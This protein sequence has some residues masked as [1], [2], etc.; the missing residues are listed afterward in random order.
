[1][2]NHRMNFVFKYILIILVAREVLSLYSPYY[3]RCRLE[4]I[5]ID[6]DAMPI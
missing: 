6:A 4:K 1:M 5:S 2:I 3:K